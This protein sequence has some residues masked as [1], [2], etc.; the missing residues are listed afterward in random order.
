MTALSTD[1][2]DKKSERHHKLWQRSHSL[3]EAHQKTKFWS[4]FQNEEEQ[5][6]VLNMNNANNQ[7][8][9]F[10]NSIT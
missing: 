8:P 2:P 9:V 7:R 5:G 4:G 6:K 3:Q 1:K 10:D